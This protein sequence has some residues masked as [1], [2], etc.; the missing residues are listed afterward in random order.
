MILSTQSIA[1]IAD[2]VK[3]PANF[4][5]VFL[6]NSVQGNDRNF[7]LNFKVFI[8]CIER[9]IEQSLDTEEEK[10]I[11][12]NVTFI[13]ERIIENMPVLFDQDAIT[14]LTLMNL[15]KEKIAYYDSINAISHFVP[16]LSE[17]SLAQ[18]TAAIAIDIIRKISLKLGDKLSNEFQNAFEYYIVSE[19]S[20]TEKKKSSTNAS[21][22]FRLEYLKW[23][24]LNILLNT[25]RID[26]TNLSY[27]FL[28]KAATQELTKEFKASKQELTSVLA[29]GFRTARVYN[30]VFALYEKDLMNTKTS[31]LS[32]MESIT[33][34]EKAAIV[35]KIKNLPQFSSHSEIN[36]TTSG[37]C[38]HAEIPEE[39]ELTTLEKA[40]DQSPWARESSTHFKA[41]RKNEGISTNYT[42]GSESAKTPGYFQGG[43]DEL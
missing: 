16:T 10:K 39:I 3:I 17:A 32:S 8:N 20:Y 25:I 38:K 14:D 37:E 42:L 35:A 5:G 26:E 41:A 36:L 34:E 12:K 15:V 11:R 23:H 9:E 18:T 7:L 40:V 29:P 6:N 30:I 2:A 13:F 21:N 28:I 19:K 31:T 27:D 22:P 1:E 43:R 4:S 24:F 33:S